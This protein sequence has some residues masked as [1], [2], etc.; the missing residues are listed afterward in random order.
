MPLY[1]CNLYLFTPPNPD[2]SISSDVREFHRLRTLVT[3]ID[4]EEDP[5]RDPGLDGTHL[6]ENMDVTTGIGL[7]P[8]KFLGNNL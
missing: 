3:D 6:N 1:F 8:R 7:R 4:Y 5:S 2:A